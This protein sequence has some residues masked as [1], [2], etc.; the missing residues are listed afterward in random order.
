ME[1]L[2]S[3]IKGFRCPSGVRWVSGIEHSDRTEHVWGKISLVIEWQKED[4][5]ERNQR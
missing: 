3:Q 4:D 5:R 1:D 2:E